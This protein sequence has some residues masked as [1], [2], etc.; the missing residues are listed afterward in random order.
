M[1]PDLYSVPC[2]ACVYCS[3]PCIKVFKDISLNKN[4]MM[5]CFILS[6]DNLPS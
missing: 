5:Y 1:T 4:I 3:A 6:N 2:D